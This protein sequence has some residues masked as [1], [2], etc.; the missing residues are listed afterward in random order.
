MLTVVIAVPGVPI[1]TAVDAGRMVIGAFTW[2]RNGLLE[3]DVAW[4]RKEA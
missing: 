4:H 1:L 3:M 2:D